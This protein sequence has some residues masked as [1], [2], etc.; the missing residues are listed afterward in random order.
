[1]TEYNVEEDKEDER[2]E[3]KEIMKEQWISWKKTTD[4]G[5]K[6]RNLKMWKSV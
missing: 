4:I 6:K 1:M 2:E 5:I 3:Q